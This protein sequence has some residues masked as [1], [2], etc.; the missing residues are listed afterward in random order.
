M[1][2]QEVKILIILGIFS[3]KF[4]SSNI[5]KIIHYTQST[6]HLIINIKN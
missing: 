5:F 4:F 2:M 3:K 1:L 6:S